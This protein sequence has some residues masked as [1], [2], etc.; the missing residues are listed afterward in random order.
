MFGIKGQCK[1]QIPGQSHLGSE[2]GGKEKAGDDVIEQRGHVSAQASSR[3]Q[4][5]Q[6]CGSGFRVKN[7]MDYWDS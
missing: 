3:I 7:R 6:S 5:F 1:E 2:E 4:Q